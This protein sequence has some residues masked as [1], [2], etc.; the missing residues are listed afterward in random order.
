MHG[1]AVGVDLGAALATWR[2]DEM[3]ADGGT[4]RC[5]ASDLEARDPGGNT[6]ANGLTL[7]WPQL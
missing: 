5:S 1:E 4:T 2:H 7:R 3:H 6:I